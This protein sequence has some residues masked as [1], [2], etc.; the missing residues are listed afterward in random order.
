MKILLGI[1]RKLDISSPAENGGLYGGGTVFSVGTNQPGSFGILH[2][3]SAPVNG[4]NSDGAYS[5]SSLYSFTGTGDGGQCRVKLL[6]VAGQG[7]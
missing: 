6:K 5:F 3:F 7:A 4:T 2:Y 1:T